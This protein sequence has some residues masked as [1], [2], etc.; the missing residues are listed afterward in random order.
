MNLHR[1]ALV[2]TTLCLY[3]PVA[4]HAQS[5]PDW[6]EE[7]M[8][9]RALGLA[10]IDLYLKISNAPVGPQL[11]LPNELAGPCATQVCQGVDVE[12]VTLPDAGWTFA[13]E[14][15]LSP[16]QLA[17]LAGITSPETLAVMGSGM[18]ATQGMINEALGFG[19][20]QPEEFTDIFELLSEEGLGAEPLMVLLNP[21][22]GFAVGGMMMQD[23]ANAAFQARSDLQTISSQAQQEFNR[24]IEIYRAAEYAGRE[25]VG[26]TPADRYEF[27][28]DSLLAATGGAGQPNAGEQTLDSATIWVDPENYRFLKQ[29]IEGKG[30]FEGE[31]RDFF[32]EIE[33]SDFRNPPG[34]GQMDQAY[35]RVSRMGGMLD[36][37]QMAQMEEARAQLAEL[38]QQLANMPA[39]Q[40]QMMERMMGS[41][42][43]TMRSL[44]NSGSFEYAEETEQI[45]C[46][47]DLASLFR[48]GPA[49]IS[50]ADLV[51]R[52]QEYL[53]I[54]GYEPGN[55]DGVLDTETTIAISQFQA[56]QRLE[57]TG[58]PSAE[59]ARILASGVEG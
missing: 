1:P 13:A 36:D 49:D 22:L 47:P 7:S 59:L 52:I 8:E 56:E 57:V 41:Q 14:V 30:N 43:A 10:N 21:S 35:R 38:E 37:E 5:L 50:D 26:S 31:V 45:I 25:E 28:G 15:P 11:A 39:Q 58:Q 48:V 18:V 9:R 34:C 33:Y 6:I 3:A 24:A 27:R 20:T 44:M 46:N 4:A 32:I 51:R 53:V 54:L 16:T 55:I 29:R 17:V 12:P 23:A 19:P 2:A 40:R 42:M